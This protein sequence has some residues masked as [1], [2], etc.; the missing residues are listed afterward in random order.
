[1]GFDVSKSFAKPRGG[2]KRQ[3]SSDQ[4]QKSKTSSPRDSDEDEQDEPMDRAYLKTASLKSLK[5]AEKRAAKVH[6]RRILLTNQ[7]WVHC[8]AIFITTYTHLLTV[9]D[10]IRLGICLLTRDLS[11][12]T[13]FVPIF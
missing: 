13:P 8:C 1:M 2:K 5:D 9:H 3:K 7:E 4:A 12:N 6:T 10:C 11:S